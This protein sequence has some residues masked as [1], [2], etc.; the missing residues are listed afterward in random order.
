MCSMIPV[1]RGAVRV[2]IGC[3]SAA[4]FA[5]TTLAITVAGVLLHGAVDPSYDG[6]GAGQGEG[7]LAG[8][9]LF[10]TPVVGLLAAWKPAVGIGFGSVIL[11]A[12]FA[13]HVAA[14]A[15]R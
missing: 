2:G 9:V 8:M 6:H 13:L 10:A 14:I 11:L 1:E 3:G 4:G 7:I 15:W 12:L 5:V